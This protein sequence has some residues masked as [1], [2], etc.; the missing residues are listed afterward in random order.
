MCNSKNMESGAS[1][2]D[3]ASKTESSALMDE[4]VEDSLFNYCLDVFS[5]IRQ[6]LQSQRNNRVFPGI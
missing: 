1:P 5:L 3:L 2:S 4:Q 6:I